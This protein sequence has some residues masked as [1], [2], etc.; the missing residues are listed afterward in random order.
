MKKLLYLG[1]ILGIVAMVIAFK[2]NHEYDTNI[3]VFMDENIENSELKIIINPN[4]YLLDGYEPDEY[5][6]ETNITVPLYKDSKLQN[7]KKSKINKYS[8]YNIYAKYNDE[9]AKI[10]Y[11][12]SL[13]LGENETEIKIFI[14]KQNNVIFLA[15][16]NAVFSI[17]AI[18]ES[19]FKAIED[20]KENKNDMKIFSDLNKL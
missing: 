5:I 13:V 16:G 6:G 9:F 1:I 7:Y 4:G 10:K 17:E 19:S 12:N 20:F 2:S 8:D 14:K 18:A 15:S 3:H 11:T